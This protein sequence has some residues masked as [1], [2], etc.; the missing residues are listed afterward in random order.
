[1]SYIST[2][3]GVYLVDFVSSSDDV[4]FNKA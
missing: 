2:K 3:E 4:A 1:V